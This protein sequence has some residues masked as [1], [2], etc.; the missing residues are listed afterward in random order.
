MIIIHTL[1]EVGK[2]HI[3][4]FLKRLAVHRV[5]SQSKSDVSKHVNGKLTG[6]E[7]V[8]GNGAQ[9]TRMTVAVRGLSKKVN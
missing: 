3:R 1:H 2:P 7:R 6:R 9:A 4:S 5:Y 8:V